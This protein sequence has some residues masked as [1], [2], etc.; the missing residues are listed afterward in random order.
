[1][2]SMLGLKVWHFLYCADRL[3]GKCQKLL[4]TV[5]L[6]CGLVAC[7]SVQLSVVANRTSYSRRGK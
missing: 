7:D 2:D 3:N 6:F 5:N 1:M 4:S